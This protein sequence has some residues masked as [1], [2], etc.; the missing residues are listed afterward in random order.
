MSERGERTARD[1]VLG[2]IRAATRGGPQPAEVPRGYR[3]AGGFPPGAPELIDLLVRRLVDYRATVHRCGPD[4]LPAAVAAALAG[5]SAVAVPPGVADGWLAA[6]TGPVSTDLRLPGLAVLTG[7]A[8]A[9]APTGTIILDAGPAQGRRE[10]S[11]VPDHHVCVVHA[12][13]VAASVPAALARLA[14]PARPL[15]LISGPSATSDIELNR[16]EGVHGPRRLDVVLVAAGRS[17]PA[18]PARA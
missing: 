10:L 6:W 3:S 1:E 8:V 14:D 7:C 2:R 5:A 9:I 15:T 17:S 12:G 13:Q 16:V 11:L 18:P 4:G